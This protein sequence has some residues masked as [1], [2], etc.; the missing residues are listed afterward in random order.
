MCID[1]KLLFSTT[2]PV[3]EDEDCVILEDVFEYLDGPPRVLGGRSIPIPYCTQL[4]SAAIPGTA[5]IVAAAEAMLGRVRQSK[6]QF[7]C[8]PRTNSLQRRS[9][10][11]GECFNQRHRVFGGSFG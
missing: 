2:G 10:L 3:L 11:F 8:C 4:E 1:H 6:T 7:N 9:R 5:D